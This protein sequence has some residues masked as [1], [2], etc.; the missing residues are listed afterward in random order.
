MLFLVAALLLS[1][2][3]VAQI[4]RPVLPQIVEVPSGNLHLKAFLWKPTGP[5][6]FPAVLF[7]HGSGGPDALHTA[8]MTLTE[9]AQ[10]L[11]PLFVK[12]GYAFL[13]LCRRGQGLSA[14]Q[15]TFMQDE[16]KKEEVARGNEARQ[17]LQFVLMNGG[18]LDDV[19]A[20]LAFI[21]N[22][23]EVDPRRVA[24]VGHS[25]GGQL[26][27][28]AAERDTTLRGV[29]TFGAAANSWEKSPELRQR[30]LTAVGK[31]TSPIMLIHAANDYDTAAGRELAARLER[32]HKPHLL[33]I[34]STVG[35]TS[36]DGHNA[37]YTAISL[38]EADVFQFLDER[39]RR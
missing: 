35:Q 18:Q 28:L 8:G 34:Y 6:E 21:K 30:L 12:H 14:D 23:A 16:L 1:Q 32:L 10:E 20:A 5:G 4:A 22:L 37:V 36:D 11:G 17:H 25:F 29:V 27:L 39:V 26:T 33:K 2:P 19:I 7:N 13:Y 24:I 38:W 31:T 3:A 15:G 9:A